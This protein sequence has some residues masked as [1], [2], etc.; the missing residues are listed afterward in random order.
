[1]DFIAIKK[2]NVA[3]PC[4]CFAVLKT[5]ILK[6]IAGFKFNKTAKEVFLIQVFRSNHN[7][8]YGYQEKPYV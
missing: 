8:S 2:S 1:M 4:T 5:L 6:N 7:Y 3:P